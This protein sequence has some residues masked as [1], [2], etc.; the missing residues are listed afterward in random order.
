MH[1]GIGA[2]Y[3]G[4]Q[5]TLFRVWAPHFDALEVLTLSEGEHGTRLT[6][7]ERGYHEALLEGVAPG[8]RYYFQAPGGERLPD[9]ASRFQPEG[10]H[11]PSQVVDLNFA[12]Q[13]DFAPAALADLVMY[14]LHIGTFTQEGTFES[15]LERLPY[16][17]ELG[18][19]AVEIMP[20]AQFPGSRNWG[21]DGVF[22][23]AAQNSYG[24]PAGF[25]RLVDA[26]HAHDLAVILD[27]VYNHLGP[28]GNLLGRFGP[29]FTSKYHTP[30]G[31]A[32][33]FDD[34]HS[35]EVRRFFIEQARQWIFDF[36]VDALR[37]DA[38]HAILDASANPFLTELADA[39][40]Q[41][42]TERGRVVYLIAESDL[43]DPRMIRARE[44][45]GHGMD[46][47]WL[48]DFHHSVHALCTAEQQGYYADFGDIEALA[49]CYRDGYVYSGQRSAFR[50]RR[51]G[52]PAPDARP[53][54]F[55]VCIQNHDQVGNRMKGDRLTALVPLD[56]HKVAAA[57]LLCGPYV[58]LLFMGEE[59][60]EPAPFPYFVSHTD[61]ELVRAV[62]AGRKREFESFAWLGEPPDPQ[63]EATF[64]SAKLSWALC[65][66]TPHREILAFY[67]RLL[68]LR[69]E[70]RLGHAPRDSIEVVTFP[71]ERALLLLRR[72][73]TLTT[74]LL[75][76]F[77]DQ[78]AR[79][80]LP[81]P[82]GVWDVLIDSTHTCWGGPNAETIA[83]LESVGMIPH[84]LAPWSALLLMQSVTP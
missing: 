24:G 8:T 76:G 16:L 52:A 21:Y 15:A 84:T 26:C 53:E 81:L 6:R 59:F 66:R 41:E 39:I 51:H 60:A 12:W 17:R 40:H 32:L 73:P 31:D 14:E 56:A 43:N 67:K 72:E 70:L 75:L 22:P 54:Q 69:R 61:A 1:G 33:N 80:D 46:A 9:P 57:A 48:D 27:V 58:P 11:G 45:G 77:N 3:L 63:A 44:V 2:L 35:D 64:E 74:A 29:Y 4:D 38:V 10:V 71:D 19:N 42:A 78:A 18:V 65:Q 5:R 68:E 34:A 28:E 50:Q 25:A 82:G 79:V 7:D 55:V 49:K 47:Q 62:R 13:H 23:Y 83:Q 36:R 30:W 37:L 20:I